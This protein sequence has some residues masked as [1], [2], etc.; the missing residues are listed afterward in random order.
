MPA[1]NA[2]LDPVQRCVGLM[3]GLR[4]G[5]LVPRSSFFQLELEPAQR[6]LLDR[7]AAGPL[8]T[9]DDLTAS[10]VL[11]V[12]AAAR[13]IPKPPRGNDLFSSE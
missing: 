7:I 1:I 11:P 2:G 12:S 13:S 8:I 5:K 6:E 10:A 3:A 4:D 9:V